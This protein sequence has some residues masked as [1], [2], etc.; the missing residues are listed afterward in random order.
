MARYRKAWA[1]LLAGL[2][3]AVPALS[4]ANNDGTISTQEWLTVLGL[5]LPAVFTALAPPNKPTTGDLVDQI[6]KNPDISLQAAAT[7]LPPTG[8]R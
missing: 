1:A 8:L 6:N 7:K 4:A 2:L 3:V 5:F